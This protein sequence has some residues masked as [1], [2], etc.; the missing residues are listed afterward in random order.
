M[1]RG[2]PVVAT[3]SD[4]KKLKYQEEHNFGRGLRVKA[5]KDGSCTWFFRQ[6]IR[7]YKTPAYQYIG[8]WPDISI[9]D[10]EDKARI[11]RLKI[12]EGVHPKDY[13]AEQLE[14]KQAIEAEEISKALTLR[15]LLEMYENSRDLYGKPNQPST[16][17]DR[18]WGISSVFAEWMDKPAQNITK[19][20]VNNKINEWSS[21]RG[22][23]GQVL[24]VCDYMSAIW[25]FFINSDVL[26]KNPFD[27]KK[28]RYTRVGKP[29]K[30][31][32]Q[33]KECK[34]M[35]TFI[36]KYNKENLIAMNLDAI[37]LTVLTGLRKDEVLNFRWSDIFLSREQ[38][39]P[40]SGPYFNI[41]KSKQQEPMGIPITKQMLPY[42]ERCLARVDEFKRINEKRAGMSKRRGKHLYNL[43]YVFPSPR[44]DKAITNSK[45]GY[46]I[47]NEAFTKLEKAKKIGAQVL[48]KTFATSA[49]SLGYT[50]EQ[51]GL[52]TGH[53]SAVAN[54]KVATDA[55]VARQAD[56][57]RKG[58]DNINSVLVGETTIDLIPIPDN[59]EVYEIAG[60]NLQ[61]RIDE[62]GER[63]EAY[64]KNP[65]PEALAKLNLEDKLLARVGEKQKDA[66]EKLSVELLDKILEK[67]KTIEE[68]E[69]D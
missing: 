34:D 63:L 9:D 6:K 2:V 40:A 48:R 25:N 31:Y 41:I 67:R 19:L 68:R 17:K 36:S 13:E 28:G 30:E 52:F 18:R 38:Y 29:Q 46:R 5:N 62:Q 58:F 7:G 60:E 35:I 42:F 54:T 56:D 51:I 23:K 39:T 3:V 37:A 57:H 66:Y 16:I 14:L 49:Y 20:V 45:A 12:S 8:D 64:K 24:K 50:M 22:S 27:I 43:D 44:T 4:I 10:A 53:T 21:Q 59:S 33:I 15:Q 1:F 26:E 65:T 69:S 11:Y 47:L 55:Y 32:L 61:A